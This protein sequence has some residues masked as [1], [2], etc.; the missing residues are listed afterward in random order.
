MQ[1][2]ALK[3]NELFVNSMGWPSDSE[4]CMIVQLSSEGILLHAN[5][6]VLTGRIQSKI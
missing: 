3:V 2:N 4:D 5:D 6:A 1:T